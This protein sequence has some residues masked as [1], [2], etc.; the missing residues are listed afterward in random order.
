ME[1]N[2]LLLSIATFT[3]V[4]LLYLA[5]VSVLSARKKHRDLK[6]RTK[7]WSEMTTQP[8][9]SRATKRESKEKGLFGLFRGKNKKKDTGIYA[10][11]PLSYQRA[12]IYNR[13]A[14]RFYR[15][16][17]FLLILPP[18]IL[19]F[20]Y[21]YILHRSLDATL[22]LG[23]TALGI[24]GY[25]FP[26]FWI[27][28]LARSRKKELNRTFPDAMDLLMVC[29]EAGMGIDSAVRRVSQ[30]IH[31]TSPALAEEFKILSLELKTGK[32]RND[33]LKNLAERTDLSDV[34]NLVSLLVQAERY[35]TGV[36]NALR[37]HA[38]EMR[39]KRFS[40]LEALAAMLPV[41][42]IVPVILFI[43]PSFFVIIAGPAAIQV[44]RVI[45]QR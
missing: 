12:G 28:L 8:D 42:I 44:L 36:A 15:F 29:V 4:L 25:L 24:S 30:E 45:I 37:T 35:G 31:I 3:V 40:R 38:E 34:N 14:I 23:A 7:K 39:Q 27:G 9:P 41:K 32:S 13:N 33:C 10:D 43:F 16:L 1:N 20:I 26:V 17:R 19:L 6:R 11:T 21:F 2:P 18:F 22:L 5:F